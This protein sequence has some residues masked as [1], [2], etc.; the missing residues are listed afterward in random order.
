LFTLGAL[1]T[2][3]TGKNWFKSGLEMLLVGGVAASAA[4]LVG[5]L[6]GGLA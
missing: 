1:K 2:I 6:L 4:Y 5:L 3:L